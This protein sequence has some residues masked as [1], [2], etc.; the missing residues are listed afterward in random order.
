MCLVIF[1]NCENDPSF[2]CTI[3]GEGDEMTLF[4]QAMIQIN[5]RINVQEAKSWMVSLS[6]GLEPIKYI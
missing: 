6:V 2:G 1:Y 5:I 3:V 4:S